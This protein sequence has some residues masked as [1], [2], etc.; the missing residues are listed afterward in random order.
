[1][2]NENKLQV[3]MNGKS[4]GTLVLYRK[5]LVAFAYDRQWLAEG[6][7]LNPYSLPLQDKV[8]IPEQDPFDGL[9]GVF[10][11]SLPDGWGHLLV[12]RMLLNFRIDPNTLNSLDRLAIVG[13][14]GMGALGYAPACPFSVKTG[15]MDFDLLARECKNI[16]ETEYS[17]DLDIL[18]QLGASSGGA[19]PKILT[20]IDGAPWIIKFPSSTDKDTIGVE[21]YRYML[22]AKSCGVT[23]PECRLFPSSVGPGYFGVRRFD[24]TPERKKVHMVS[25]SGLLETSHRIPNLDYSALMKLGLQLTED[26]AE[27]E[28]LYRLM[29]FNVFAHNRD[30]HSKNFSFLYDEEENRWKLSPAYDL[31]YSNSLGGEHATTINGNGRNPV[32]ADILAVAEGIGIGKQKAKQIARQVQETVSSGLDDIIQSHSNHHP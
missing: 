28:K 2:T 17:P 9:Y 8:F 3:S 29:C 5:R 24:R 15:T 27:V 26:Y 4:V 31:T 32:M 18:F 11:D 22:C 20:E 16:L 7:S 25:V 13:D 21:E 1:M 6:F 14:S 19:R 23:V 10:S 30:D 12:D